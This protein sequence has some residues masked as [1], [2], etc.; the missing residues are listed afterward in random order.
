M[1]TAAMKLKDAY[2]LERKLWPVDSI[3]KSRDI[4]L[5]TKVHLVKAMVLPVIMYGSDYKESW[6]PKNWSFWTVMLEKTFESSLDCKKIQPVHPKG[7]QLNVH[8][9]DWWSWNSNTLATWCKELTHWK[10]SWCWGKLK[11]GGEG[12]DRGWDGCMASPI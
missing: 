5:S 11:A 4:I 12:D 1:V 2:S 8:W 3:L 10:R 7:D 9:E 6:V